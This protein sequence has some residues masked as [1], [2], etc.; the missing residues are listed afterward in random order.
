MNATNCG[1]PSL[2]RV[3]LVGVMTSLARKLTLAVGVTAFEASEGELV[4]I[5]FVAVTVKV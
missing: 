1:D 2:S 5:A 4:P 3:K